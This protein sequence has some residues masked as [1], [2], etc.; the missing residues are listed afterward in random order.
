MIVQYTKKWDECGVVRDIVQARNNK[1]DFVFEC[2]NPKSP[3]RVSVGT[4]PEGFKPTSGPA[5]EAWQIELRDLKFVPLIGRVNCISRSYSGNDDGGEQRAS[6][7]RPS[8]NAHPRNGRALRMIKAPT[9]H[10]FA[11]AEFANC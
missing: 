4:W 7:K 9:S 2:V 6:K 8:N 10:I 5:L 11:L 1:V 3:S